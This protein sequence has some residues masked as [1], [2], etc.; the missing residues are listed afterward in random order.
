MDCR[1]HLYFTVYGFQLAVF[2]CKLD[3]PTNGGFG[4]YGDVVLSKTPFYNNVQYHIVFFSLSTRVGAQCIV[5]TSCLP[6]SK[7]LSHKMTLV[8]YDSL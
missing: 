6:L 7:W 1:R 8:T 2:L 4:P 5:Q 3:G